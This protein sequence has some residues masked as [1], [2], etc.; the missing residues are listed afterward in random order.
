MGLLNAWDLSS[1]ARDNRT[2]DYCADAILD[3]WRIG[4]LHADAIRELNR[5]ESARTPTIRLTC[6]YPKS[7][8]AL[9]AKLAEPQDPR[10]TNLVWFHPFRCFVLWKISRLLTG[11]RSPSLQTPRIEKLH[12]TIL[13]GRFTVLAEWIERADI[14]ERRIQNW[15]DL[16]SLCVIGEPPSHIDIFQTVRRKG[17]TTFETTERELAS[18]DA[19]VRRL[20]SAIDHS[21]LNEYR[22]EIRHE[23]KILDPNTDLHLLIRLANSAF[24][25]R[26]KGHISGA[27]LLFHM[28]EALRRTQERSAANRTRESG[29]CEFSPSGYRDRECLTDETPRILDGDRQ[30]SNQ[31][32]RYLGLDYGL[33]VKIYVEGATEYGCFRSEFANH[34]SVS[35]VDLRGRF[36]DR[37]DLSFSESLRTDLESRVFSLIVLDSDRADNLRVVRQAVERD[38][39]CGLFFMCDPDFEFAN[40]T[41]AELCRIVARMLEAETP[42]T[43]GR[44]E[45]ATESC[46]TGAEMFAAL[47]PTNYRIEKGAR[48]GKRLLEYATEHPRGDPA[49]EDARIIERVIWTAYQCCAIEY[50]YSR[51][52]C[53]VDP[54]TGRLVPRGR[55]L[56]PLGASR[57]SGNR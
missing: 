35:V 3:L 32:L 13:N 31:Y 18:L 2:A 41:R 24:R 16:V 30:A 55:P 42:D 47:R 48:W 40:F 1:L 4:F 15:N 5:E 38:Q 56:K 43:I 21:S 39:I 7:L 57:T 20:M 27:M 46:T 36:V 26:L 45:Q 53:R 19:D 50:Q 54:S 33:R 28:G 12:S 23:S 25:K 8:D 29:E 52:S 11:C 17:L 22:R 37:G 34:G 9:Q 10:A 14:H 51:E 49:E 6:P 44:I